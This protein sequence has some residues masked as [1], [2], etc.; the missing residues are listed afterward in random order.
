MVPG[1]TSRRTELEWWYRL[2]AGG[3][4]ARRL[5][6]RAEGRALARNTRRVE[7]LNGR[8][9][10]ETVFILGSGP[11]LGSLSAEQRAALAGRITIGV[12]RTQYV[13]P[14]TY[15]LSAYPSEVLLA[16][17][18]PAPMTLIHMRPGYGAPVIRGAITLQRRGF[19]SNPVLPTSL[20]GAPP[21]VV[22][23][24]NVA[25]G[26]TNLAMIMGAA[27]IVYVGVEQQSALHYYDTQAELRGRI[28]RDLM[29]IASKDV[30]T[31]DHPHATFEHMREGLL[32]EP[33][34]MAATEFWPFSFAPTFRAYF[35]QIRQHGVEPVA[36]LRESVVFEAGASL[37]GL[38]DALRQD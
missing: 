18:H 1:M 11:Q 31:L 32:K 28:L 17:V 6:P 15:F 4:L 30:F 33:E 14:P 37:Q 5:A 23:Y 34:P 38:D 12:N 13:Q 20:T 16:Q 24:R 26:A 25:L 36:T 35:E 2:S 9:T 10:G 7:A 22:T 3:A 8:H 21:Y 19:P 27:R 29:S